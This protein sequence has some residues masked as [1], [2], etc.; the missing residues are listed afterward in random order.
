[1]T[2]VM[3]AFT[4]FH[5]RSAFSFL[6]A[7]SLPEDLIQRAADLGHCGMALMDRD[8]LCGA[9]RF[10]MAAKKLKIPAHIGAEIT[11]ADG[12]RY[13]LLVEN[14]TGYQNLCRLITSMKLRAPKGQAAASQEELERHAEGLVCLTGEGV[15]TRARFE[16]LIRIFGPRNLYAELQRHFHRDEE[17][18]NQ[19]VIELA[20]SMNLP[21]LAT[22]G[23]RHAIQQERELFDALTA[24]HHKTTV[25]EA[26]QLLARNAER[27]LKSPRMMAR[28]F[29]DVPEAVAETVELSA[30][31]GFTLADLGYEFPKYPVPPG[32]TMNS[33][34]RQRTDE[35]ARRRYIPYHEQARKQIERELALIEKL[36]LAGYFL[37]VW[38]LVQ[39]CRDHGILAQGRGSA[40][41]SAVCYS[42][43]ITA[44]DPVAMELLFER[45]LSDERGEWPDID[46]D[47]PS[48]DQRER[49]IQYVY[50]RYG[51]RGAAMTAN[52]IT[53]R[54]RSAARDIGKALGF[55][56]E[57]LDRLFGAGGALGVERS[58]RKCRN[59]S[60]SKR[61]SIWIIPAFK[62]FS[63]CM[64]RRKVCLVIWVSIPA[65]W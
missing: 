1:M 51:Q 58:E 53:Y 47:L 5:S 14:R 55:E 33:F 2:N 11:G 40:A 41:N 17:A 35:G 12:D 13:P 39:F 22:N 9:P 8:N 49:V 28:L 26:G 25:M 50:Q 4:E 27:Y 60:S 54:G 43:G 3:L 46:L 6:E 19:A 31:L 15:P 48:G 18:R 62:P 20:R 36:N 7:A 52:I 23:V 56:P 38:D 29:A 45:F 42:L 44:V 24:V 32:E 37:I 57:S 21:L 61:G 10:Y 30:R 65:A 63:S 64:S 59:S 34:L 16:K